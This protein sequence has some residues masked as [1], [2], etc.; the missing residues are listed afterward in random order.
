MK[1][2]Y[3]TI[4]VLALVSIIGC[5]RK[6]PVACI[7]ATKTEALVN[8]ELSFASCATDAASVTWNFGDATT[9]EGESTLHKYTKAGTYAVSLRAVSKKNKAADK[10]VVIVTIKD[11]PLTVVKSRYL[12]KIVLKAFPQ[13]NAGSK[14]D[15]GNGGFG[16]SDADLFIN[17]GTDSTILYH[18]EFVVNATQAI[19]PK[20]YNV[21]AFNYKLENKIYFIDLGDDDG[22]NLSNLTWTKIRTLTA[23]LGTATA[24]NGK[25]TIVNTDCSVDVYFE[26]R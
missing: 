25:I 23:N 15:A 1:K 10:A 13:D 22:A 9:A 18:S 24:T 26:E 3:V 14:W 12:T 4:A 11:A 21:A 2:Q 5:K 8:E 17:F 19:L 7:T 20:T 16:S 6:L